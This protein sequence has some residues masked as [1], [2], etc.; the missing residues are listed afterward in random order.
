[1]I[2]LNAPI[3]CMQYMDLPEFGVFRREVDA[4]EVEGNV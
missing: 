1:M 2:I 4:R 3:I